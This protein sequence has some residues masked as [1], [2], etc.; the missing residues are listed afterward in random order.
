MLVLVR[1]QIEWG[2][3][4][5]RPADTIRAASGP[6]QGRARARWAVKPRRVG[7]TRD[8]AAASKLISCA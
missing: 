5:C 7:A 2:V 6:G 3:V 8:Q 1:P 4:G